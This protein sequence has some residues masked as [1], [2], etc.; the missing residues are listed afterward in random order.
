MTEPWYQRARRWGQTNLTEIDPKTY[1][2]DWWRDYW[3]RTRVQGVIVNAGG[4]VAYYPSEFPLHYRAEHL[5]DRDL[6]G[7]IVELARQEGLAVLARMD[8][9]RALP[10][11]QEKHPDW[12]VTDLAGNSSNAGGRCQACVNSPYYKEYIP[13]VFR[14][15]I[16]RYH[17]DGFTDN[18]WTGLNRQWICHCIHCQIKFQEDCGLDLPETADFDDEV[19]CRWIRW[20]YSCRMENWDLNN[21]ITRKHGGEHCLWLGMINGDPVGTHVSFCDLKEAG[22]RSKL[23]M[24]DQQSRTFTG[25]EQNAVSGKLLHSVMGW[26]KQIPESMAMYVRGEQTFRRA[27]NPPAETQQWMRSGFAGGISPWWHHVGAAQEDRRQFET[28]EALMRW[29]EANEAYLYDREPVANVALL[30][31]HENIDFYGRDNPR[32]VTQ[33]PWRGFNYALTRRRMPHLPL[34][35]DHLVRDAGMLDVAILPDLA[36]MSDAQ[37]EAVAEFVRNGGSVVATAASSL[38]DEWGKPRPDFGLSEVFGVSA[39]GETLGIQGK[40]NPDWEVH[41]GHNYFRIEDRHETVRGF[42][43]TEILPFGGTLQVVKTDADVVAT[44]IPSFQ[45][46]PPEFS[47]MREPKSDIPAIVARETGFGGRVVYFAGDI[48]R[49]LGRR[50]LPDHAELLANAVAWAAKDRQALKVEGP[51][52]LDCTLYRQGER[53]ILHIVN[54]TGA[55]NWPGYLEA[56]PPVGPIR[57]SLDGNWQEARSLVSNEELTVR[58]NGETTVVEL[59]KIRE[60]DVIVFQ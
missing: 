30:W 29:H 19:Y 59:E 17:P 22:A 13:S 16:E 51:G 25:F 5:G 41:T 37:C 23:I 44:Y 36:V 12:F 55:N 56:V 8:S 57:I 43:D 9:N 35:V 11:F 38:L 4:I 48:D 20:S 40:H 15:I 58:G 3:R 14:E 6:F 2:A 32:E 45:I 1:D 47:W 7:E 53:R 50:G 52:Y 49:C 33:Y 60:H 21:R 18:S 42:D 46:Y 39:T 54:L 31:S 27:A 26:D 24:C 10:E 34:H 28:T